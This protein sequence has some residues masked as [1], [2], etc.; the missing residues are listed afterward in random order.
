MG[1]LFPGLMSARPLLITKISHLELMR[2]Q[3]IAFFTIGIVK[4]GD[5]GGT[6]GIVFYPGHLSR[7]VYFL[8][9]KIDT[10]ILS[11][12]TAPFIPAGDTAIIIASPG[13]G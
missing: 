6:I 10:S 1:R 8:P 2:G 3:N 11:F 4:Q 5:P 12:M 13:P 9:L 7:N